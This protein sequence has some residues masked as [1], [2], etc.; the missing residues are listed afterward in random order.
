[1]TALTN[2]PQAPAAVRA[3]P[4]HAAQPA[5]VEQPPA[6]GTDSRYKCTYT[7]EPLIPWSFEV[8]PYAYGSEAC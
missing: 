5:I 3:A 8:Y 2:E 6:Q 7:F 4:I 1:V